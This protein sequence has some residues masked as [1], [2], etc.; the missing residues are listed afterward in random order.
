MKWPAIWS[1]FVLSTAKSSY[2][3]DLFM[4]IKIAVAMVF[5]SL[6]IKINLLYITVNPF[7]TVLSVIVSSN[8]FSMAKYINCISD[9]WNM[10]KVT[11]PVK[12]DKRWT[13]GH[14]SLVNQC[15]WLDQDQTFLLWSLYQSFTAKVIDQNRLIITLLLIF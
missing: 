4:T 2:Y 7:C 6:Y 13:V 8:W 10:S 15:R 12:M 1:S 9:R 3:R 11:W 5:M 14:S